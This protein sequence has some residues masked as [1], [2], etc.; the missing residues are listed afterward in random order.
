MLFINNIYYYIII[1]KYSNIMYEEE[2][3]SDFQRDHFQKLFTS[4]D[5]DKDG[6]LNVSELFSVMKHV[7]QEASEEEIKAAIRQINEEYN[8][9]ALKYDNKID[10][11]DFI[12]L[13]SKTSPDYE[14]Q[15]EIIAAFK[16]FDKDK[17]G[18]INCDEFKHIMMTIGDKM[19]EEDIDEMFNWANITEEGQINYEEFVRAMVIN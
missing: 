9:S 7:G 3:I 5:K 12:T 18:F 2:F 4:F 13:M 10:L 19:T 6:Y 15:N 16:S 8:K 14:A 11:C 17:T 1:T